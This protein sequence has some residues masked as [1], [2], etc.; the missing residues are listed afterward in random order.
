VSSEVKRIHLTEIEPVKIRGNLSWHPVRK[1]LGISAFGINAYTAD[2]GQEVIEAHDET[3]PGAGHHEEVYVV[4]AG[5][6]T[7]TVNGADHDARAGTILFLDDPTEHRQAM[8]LEDGT[9]VLAVGGQTNA[10]FQPSPWEYVFLAI[11]AIEAKQWEEARAR[12]LEGLK[13]YPGNG[14]L[15]YDLACVEA[16]EGSRDEAMAHLAAAV[17]AWPKFRAHAARDQ[18]FTSL[19]DDARFAD[20]FGDADIDVG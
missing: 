7:F 17:E 8:A 4:L 19:H 9:T 15:L 13:H 1:A 12:L 5:R 6:A 2:A 11:P 18:D 14:S 20:F 3:G 16:R 10:T